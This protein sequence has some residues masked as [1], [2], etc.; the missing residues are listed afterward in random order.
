MKRILR[1]PEDRWPLTYTMMVLAVQLGLFFG[2][3]ASG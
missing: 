3:G 2:V 1:Y